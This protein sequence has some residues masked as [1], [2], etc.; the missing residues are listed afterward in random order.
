MNRVCEGDETR[1]K[2]RDVGLKPVVSPNATDAILSVAIKNF[3]K[4]AT[5]S[6]VPCDALS[7]TFGEPRRVET[8]ST[9]RSRRF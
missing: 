7:K 9:L 5:K 1:Q 6:N 4:A 2:A 8:S 3:T